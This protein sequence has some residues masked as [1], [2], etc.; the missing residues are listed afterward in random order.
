MKDLRPSSLKLWLYLNKNSEKFHLELSNR[1]CLEWGI[2]K[3]SYYS[4]IEE[5]IGKGYLVPAR[6]GSNQYFFDELP[7]PEFQKYNRDRAKLQAEISES[8]SDFQE[9]E[10]KFQRNYSGKP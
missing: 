9:N 3:D 4:A 8:Y 10:A 1:A 2:K 5:L 7:L 6:E